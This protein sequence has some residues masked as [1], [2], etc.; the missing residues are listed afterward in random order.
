MSKMVLVHYM[1]WFTAA[2]E[3]KHW[4]G[5]RNLRDFDPERTAD[6]GRRRIASNYYP[7]EGPYNSADIA[8]IKG[9]HSGKISSVLGHD[10]GS[11]VVH[12]NNLVVL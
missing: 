12:R 9:T 7:L 10:Y 4:R 5:E 3:W 6:S 2:P 8:V 11:E 1:P